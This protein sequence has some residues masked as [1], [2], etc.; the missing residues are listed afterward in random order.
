MVI[1]RSAEDDTHCVCCLPASTAKPRGVISFL[2]SALY[3]LGGPWQRSLC[4][5]CGVARSRL[6][7]DRKFV[8]VSDMTGFTHSTTTWI[9]YCAR[10]A[11]RHDSEVKR[12]T[13]VGIS[14]HRNDA[15]PG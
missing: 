11:T 7:E 6:R 3:S 8:K 14:P 12:G 9:K 10:D 5:S 2:G 15:K 1:A 4:G 13:A